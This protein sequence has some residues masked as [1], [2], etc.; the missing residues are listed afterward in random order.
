M[1]LA[2]SGDTTA[3]TF[4]GPAPTNPAHRGAKNQFVPTDRIC[5]SEALAGGLTEGVCPAASPSGIWCLG[6]V[7]LP[8]G[9]QGISGPGI[10]AP[11]T[12]P[13]PPTHYPTHPL[14]RPLRKLR[15]QAQMELA[16]RSCGCWSAWSG[17]G[18][19]ESLKFSVSR[20][21]GLQTQGNASPAGASGSRRM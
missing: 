13:T 4:P 19:G 11:P 8:A 15:A 1:G 20:F 12:G 7:S 18:L 3:P 2:W 10:L 16:A 9:F 21:P 6:T 17:G 14:P 5:R